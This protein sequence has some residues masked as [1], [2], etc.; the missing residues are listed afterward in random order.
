VVTGGAL[1][2]TQRARATEATRRTTMRWALVAG[3]AGLALISLSV[4]LVAG[5]V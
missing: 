4:F 1:L 3:F 2:L 5:D